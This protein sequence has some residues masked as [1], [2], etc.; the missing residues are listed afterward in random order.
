GNLHRKGK[1]QI[2][3][4][5]IQALRGM[6]AASVEGTFLISQHCPLQNVCSG[7]CCFVLAEDQTVPFALRFNL[8]L[9]REKCK[10]I[11]T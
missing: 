5:K 3:R 7:Q 6:D 4:P 9:W 10:D 8:N 11:I 2:S 1:A